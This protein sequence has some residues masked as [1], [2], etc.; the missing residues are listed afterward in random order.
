M[1]NLKVKDFS[2][3]YFAFLI[4]HLA[5]IYKPDANL[6]YV[7]K[8]L[9]MVSLMLFFLSRIE[10]LRN[11]TK[12]FIMVS[13]LFSLIGDVFLLKTSEFNFLSG[14]GCFAIAHISYALFFNRRR[15]GSI[16]IPSLVWN[17]IF[18]IILLVGLNQ[19]IDI[20]QEMFVP[21]NV[22][23]S[24]LGLNLIAAVQFNYSNRAENY[25]V[26]AGVF[27]FVVSDLILAVNKFE[28]YNRNLEYLI[29][30]TYAFAQYLIVLGVLKHFQIFKVPESDQKGSTS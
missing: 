7:S 24:I 4:F 2:K 22:Y 15:S 18:V 14:V 10:N 28:T 29:I 30:I 17:L 5:M 1:K 19:L 16:H 12:W 21:V 9:L 23:G 20:P 6:L 26:P 13:L 27:L 8:P 11:T 25:W 3:L